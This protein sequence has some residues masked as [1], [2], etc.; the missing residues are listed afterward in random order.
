M[1]EYEFLFTGSAPPDV[2]V[3]LATVLSDLMVQARYGCQRAELIR[4]GESP[5]PL[6]LTRESFALGEMA[7]TQEMAEA[8]DDHTRLSEEIEHMPQ[9]SPDVTIPDVDAEAEPGF[10]ADVETVAHRAIDPAAFARL[11]HATYDR[12]APKYGL[13]HHVEVPWDLLTQNRRDLLTAVCAE[14]QDDPMFRRDAAAAG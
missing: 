4:D 12:L 13:S 10:P 9:R 6:A 11:V 1:S 14:V 3:E 5:V 2:L 8:A 7:V